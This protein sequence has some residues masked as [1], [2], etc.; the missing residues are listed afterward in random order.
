MRELRPLEDEATYLIGEVATFTGVTVHTL[1]AWEAVGLLAPRRSTGG[2]RQYTEDD[3]ARVRLVIRMIEQH[4]LSRRAIAT[5]LRRGDLLP[6]AADY[7]PSAVAPHR[8]RGAA[9]ATGAP[10][11][12]AASEPSLTHIL[13]SLSRV[14]AA[15]ASGRPLPEVL[16]VLCKETCAAFGV[17]DTILW[18]I[19]APGF[20]T[21][22]IGEPCLSIAAGAGSHAEA[23][24]RAPDPR[25]IPLSTTHLPI[26]RILRTHRPEVISLAAASPTT[27]P[28]IAPLLSA[29]ALLVAPLFSQHGE[30]LGV[31]ALREALDAGRFGADDREYAHL[32]ASQ[33]ALAIDTARLQADLRAARDDAERER[34]VWRAAV[35]ELPELVCMCDADLHFTYASPMHER[36]LQRS[37]DPTLSPEELPIHYGLFMPDGRAPFPPEELVFTR[38]LRE[39]APVYDVETLHRLPDGREYL[40]IWAGA[41]MYG[42]DGTLLGVVSVG[43]D[44][45][46]QRRLERELA[47]RARE[48]DAVIEAIPDGVVHFD[49]HNQITLLNKTM[50]TLF[51][52]ESQRKTHSLS[53]ERRATHFDLRDEHSH[54]LPPP[55]LPSARLLRGEPLGPDGRMDM[56]IQMPH[57]GVTQ[58]SISGATISDAAEHITGAL[59]ILRDVTELRRQAERMTC[60]TAV[61][62]AAAG[63]PDPSGVEGRAAHLLAA[64]KEHAGLPLLAAGIYLLDHASETVSLAGH[65]TSEE[66]SG[67]TAGGIA[68]PLMRQLALSPRHPAWGMATGDARYSFGSRRPP[69]W[70]GAPVVGAWRAERLRGWATAPVR[71]GDVPL[72]VLVMALTAPHLWDEE[73]R[74]WFAACADAVAMGLE[75][76][77]LFAAERRR[78][79]QLDA[80]FEG[81][82]DGITLIGADGQML[83][84]NSAAA[85][86]TG[87]KEFTGSIASNAPAYALRHAEIGTP[88]PIEQIPFMRALRGERVRE[89]HLLMR[90]GQGRDRVMASASNPIRDQQQ[91]VVGAVTIFRD[92]TAETRRLELV[93]RVG[94]RLGASLEPETEMRTLVDILVESEIVRAAGVYLLLPDGQT[95]TLKAVRVG[96]NAAITV[97][98][99]AFPIHHAPLAARALETGQPQIALRDD[100][101]SAILPR[102]AMLLQVDPEVVATSMLPLRV[103]TR[104]LGVLAVAV[105]DLAELD[106]RSLMIL[107]EAARHAALLIDRAERHQR[108]LAEATAHPAP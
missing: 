94:R 87:H 93:R 99:G 103:D 106:S 83:M 36:L 14:S 59:I 16:E 97:D 64:L 58:F 80:V 10:P 62:R 9:S 73:E 11:P 40:I 29:A 6:D 34:R 68:D 66:G 19:E 23:A 30:P 57:G 49:E 107:T 47:A 90:D 56:R 3:V 65:V 104:T 86:L 77:R 69:E 28:E 51:A 22:Q 44:I 21:A 20:P 60:L 95:L 82:E 2:V 102:M 42:P 54:A 35:D 5:L 8:R 96:Q 32:F 43:H 92:I 81:V 39:R 76:D 25:A 37:A 105:T 27:H 26:A 31:L 84:R 46:E 55:M 67:A 52:V 78:Q 18:L 15:V 75:N 101:S 41:P 24:L 70:L 1:R 89:S 71:S 63:A 12:D 38:V 7:G 33:A 45:T 79:E 100:P 48:L 50:R 17:P 53:L 108:L 4:H 72:G 98:A 61:T 91:A 88:L 13:S 74:A 85:A